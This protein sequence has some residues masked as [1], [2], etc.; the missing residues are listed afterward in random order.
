M[1][2]QRNGRKS[3][4]TIKFAA[5]KHDKNKKST[6]DTK[7]VI[8]HVDMPKHVCNNNETSKKQAQ[9]DTCV[10][11]ELPHN[12]NSPKNDACNM[13]RLLNKNITK[14]EICTNRQPTTKPLDEN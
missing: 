1:V 14:F 8:D 4:R 5:N 6:T 12:E 2:R 13:N 3:H 11:I 10:V 7:F 9:K